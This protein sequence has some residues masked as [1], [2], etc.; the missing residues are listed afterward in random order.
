MGPATACE[1]SSLPLLPAAWAGQDI[2]CKL[3]QR[4]LSPETLEPGRSDTGQ[5]VTRNGV[6]GFGGLRAAATILWRP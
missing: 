3:A 4:I 1:G 2:V 5:L 6:E